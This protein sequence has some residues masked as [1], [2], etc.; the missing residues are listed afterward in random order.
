MNR[1]WPSVNA[2]ACSAFVLLFVAAQVL[3]Q[4]QNEK[5]LGT[6]NSVSGSSVTIASD[7]GKQ[8][9]VVLTGSTRILRAS[10][11]QNQL[12]GATPAS[13]SEI[14]MGD[15]LLARGQSSGES[16][17][18]ASLVI[19]M[20]KSEIA[21]RQKQE[22]DEWRRGI[23]GIVR[24]VNPAAKTITI[25]NAFEAS[26]KP[27]LIHTSGTTVV[28]RYSPDSVNFEDSKPGSFDEIKPG[29][30]LRARGT[31]N[32]DGTEF[33]AEAMVSGR[34]R[35]IA[36]T[37]ISVDQATNTIT[38]L[39]L[40]AKK[41]LTTKVNAASDLRKLPPPVAQMIA[42]RLKP[43]GTSGDPVKSPGGSEPNHPRPGNI[44]AGRAGR[45][46]GGDHGP[47]T[48]SKGAGNGAN[49][50]Q[51][52]FQ[53]MLNRLPT[54]SIGDLQ[55]GQAVMLVSTEGSASSRPTVI[56][57]LAGVE[58]L[59]TAAPSTAT[60]TSILSPWNLGAAAGGDAASQ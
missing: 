34:F 31:R 43:A 21:E 58:P 37:V 39:D 33:S 32:G 44:E 60:A 46:P 40:A 11:G 24:E 49:N 1:F 57:V 36:G 17:L 10:P 12:Q 18:A 47:E 50:R 27:I 52:D 7:D 54:I 16:R 3:A 5:V 56:K 48:E 55:K 26:G 59:L 22:R 13:A 20:K 45:Q 41:P 29:D 19:L 4:A 9:T 30:Q 42:I 25:A 6:V 23:G 2:L 15:R 38:V 51:G 8:T 14:E 28:R 35:Y 53:Q